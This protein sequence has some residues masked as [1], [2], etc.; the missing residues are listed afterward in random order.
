MNG[1]YQRN[2]KNGKVISYRFTACIGRD[3]KGKQI[4]CYATWSPPLELSLE[5]A[6]KAAERAA[7]ILL[8]GSTKI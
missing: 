8:R 2:T 1:K 7:D 4:R 5:K 6:K 3:A